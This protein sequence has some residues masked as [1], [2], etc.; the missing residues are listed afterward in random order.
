MSNTL[1]PLTA[2]VAILIARTG[3]TIIRFCEGKDAVT[4]DTAIGMLH[5]EER[6]LRLFEGFL[7][8]CG[9]GA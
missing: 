1:P 7:R 9:P 8:E 2:A 3:P 6:H 4:Q 5:D